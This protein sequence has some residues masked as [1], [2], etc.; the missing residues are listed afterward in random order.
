VKFIDTEYDFVPS[1]SAPA[2]TCCEVAD[3]GKE[4]LQ[5]PV[6][7]P[8]ET[9]ALLQF[10]WTAEVGIVGQPMKVLDPACTLSV[11]FWRCEPLSTIQLKLPGK[12]PDTCPES[13][14]TA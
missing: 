7:D 5:A 12:D 11:Q 8:P 1:P 14:L 9:E 13:G 6:P 3:N 4:P 2:A 10:T